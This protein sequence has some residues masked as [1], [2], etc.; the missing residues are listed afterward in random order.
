MDDE[1][2]TLRVWE[3]DQDVDLGAAART[4]LHDLE[5]YRFRAEMLRN[6]S[7]TVVLQVVGPGAPTGDPHAIF[8]VERQGTFVLARREDWP[9][10]GEGF[11]PRVVLTLRAFPSRTIGPRRPSSRGNPRTR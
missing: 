4:V 3:F 6:V 1:T 9:P 10:S 11:R 5:P 8:Y 2:C 7:D